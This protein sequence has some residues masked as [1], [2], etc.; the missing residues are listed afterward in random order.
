MLAG[1][2]ELSLAS[3]PPGAARLSGGE[4]PPVAFLPGEL[5]TGAVLAP[6]V[7]VPNAP[8]APALSRL[9]RALAERLGTGADSSATAPAVSFVNAI[10][11]CRAS[12]L[13]GL[14]LLR[15]R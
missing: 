13:R 2:G 7:G 12:G 10:G 1:A 6:A 14:V 5:R 3:K 9:G 8:V 15:V 4:A 11:A